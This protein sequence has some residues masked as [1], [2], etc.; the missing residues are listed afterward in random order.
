MGLLEGELGAYRECVCW[1][2]GKEKEWEGSWPPEPKP[3]S[4][5]GL[6]VVHDHD[7][8][9]GASGRR[10]SQTCA[11]T[12]SAPPGPA[13]PR[14]GNCAPRVG[15]APAHA[16]SPQPE[17]AAT[18]LTRCKLT[19]AEASEMGQ[20]FQTFG[21]FVKLPLPRLSLPVRLAGKLRARL[22]PAWRRRPGA[23]VCPS[24]RHPRCLPAL[25][26]VSTRP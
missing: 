26:P 19:A 9:Q 7:S 17:P 5:A 14:G 16:R 21:F 25:P 1:E 10:V 24:L 13:T 20:A 12:A 11:L 3:D 8:G 4:K 22:G 18:S 6:R 15:P 2:R 23:A